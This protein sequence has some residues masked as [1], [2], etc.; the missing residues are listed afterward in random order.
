MKIL[1]LFVITSIFW[2]SCKKTTS[3]NQILSNKNLACN[4]PFNPTLEKEILK[5]LNIK[6]IRQKESRNK[7]IEKICTVVVMPDFNNKEECIVIVKLSLKIDLSKLTGYTFIGNDLVACYLLSDSCG[8][9]M[10][11]KNNL[12][13]FKDSIPGYPD[14]LKSYQDMIYDAPSCTYKIVKNDSLKLIDSVFLDD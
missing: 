13:K 7:K 11:N 14:V 12:T 10:I 4:N 2:G 9:S 3:E 8:F 1:L 6:E 5:L